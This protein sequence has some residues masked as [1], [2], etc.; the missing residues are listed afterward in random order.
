MRRSSVQAGRRRRAC[1][2]DLR[3]RGYCSSPTNFVNVVTVWT[4]KNMDFS[5]NVGNS[6][7]HAVNFYFNQL[8]GNVRITVDDKLVVKDFRMFS[9]S[10]TKQYEFSVGEREVHKVAIVIIR[11]Q[12]LGGARKQDYKVYV[13]G[14][15]REEH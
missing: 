2:I 7:K 11:R 8:I 4:G 5:F 1:G 6:E 14:Q 12:I 15:F 13:D 10:L 9:A 3:Q